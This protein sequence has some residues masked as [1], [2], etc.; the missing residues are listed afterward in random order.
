MEKRRR[1]GNDDT[2]LAKCIDGFLT[3]LDG[4]SQISFPDVTAGDEAEREDDLG[5]FHRLDDFVKLARSPVKIN[6]ETSDGKLGNKSDIGV[7]T[8]KVSGEQDLGCDKRKFSIGSGELLL[9][10]GGAVENEDGL[11]DLDPLSPGNLEVSQKLLVDG[12]NT[13]EEG[14]GLE[15]RFGLFRGLRKRKEGDGT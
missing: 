5:R 3:Q 15:T 6:V 7:E 10:I 1:G 2:V 11:V 9:E 12:E 8:A 13:R 4:S 14:D